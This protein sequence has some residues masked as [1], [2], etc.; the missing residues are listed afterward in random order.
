MTV[1]EI[2]RWFHIL[3]AAVWIGGMITM[4]VLIPVLRKGGASRELI[5]AGA[6]RY[7]MASWVALTVSVV[8]GILQIFRLDAELSGALAIK[9]ILVSVSIT[10]A[11]VHQ[12]IARHV[13]PAARGAME[14]A[15]L[16][17]GLGILAAA[18]A[19]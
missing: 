10:L 8:T 9:L 17:L 14:A 19:I 13:R 2:I 1:N 6:R 15:L 4:A 12:E 18:V 7:G 3:A 16:V 11:F 5:Q